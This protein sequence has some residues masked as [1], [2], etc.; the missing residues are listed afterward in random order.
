[1]NWACS[2]RA[3]RPRPRLRHARALLLAA[4][5]GIGAAPA[6]AASITLTPGADATLFEVNPNNSAG[7]AD[8]FIAGTTQNRTRNRAL[9]WFD[10]ASALPTGAQITGVNLQLEVTRRPADGFEP[11]LFGLHRMLRPWGEGSTIPLNNPGGLGAPAGAGDATWLNAFHASS[12]WAEPG[13]ANGLDYDSVV[14]AGA[15]IYGLGSY[16]FE[17]T[18]DLINDVQGWLTQPQSNFG[19]ML[20]VEDEDLPFTARRFGSRTDPVNTPRLTID[21]VVVPEPGPTALAGL[22]LAL[23]G[24]RWWR[25]RPGPSRPGS[26]STEPPGR[27]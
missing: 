13:G 27:S 25:S 7:G 23:L 1:M 20:R 9:L 11:A 21:F 12:A 4:W 14:S 15:F 24:I 19:W 3:P 26:P 10:I 5:V 18:Q 2:N 22:G 6:P 16:Q 17:G 8:F